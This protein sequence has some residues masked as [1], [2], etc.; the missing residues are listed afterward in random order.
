MASLYYNTTHN[1]IEQIR[2]PLGGGV[3]RSTYQNIGKN[4]V[5]GW[6]LSLTRKWGQKLTLT[7]TTNLRHIALE[8]VAMQQV[9]KAYQY[10]G[11]FYLNCN[12][13]K[14]YSID[15]MGAAGSPD[16]SL[17]GKRTVWQYYGLAVNKKFK[18]D[19][20]SI[21]FRADNFLSPTFLSLRQTLETAVFT[22]YATTSYQSRYL[23]LSVAWKLGKKEVKAPVI[24]QEAGSEN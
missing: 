10:S 22:Q 4:D 15:A 9:R 5:L 1:S 14:G 17:Q 2:L 12:I 3:F 7:V 21:N 24:R 16:I 23:A 19:K 6:L 11:N 13:G 20:L 18:D 8:S